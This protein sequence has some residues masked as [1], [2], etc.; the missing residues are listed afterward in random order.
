MPARPYTE[1]APIAARDETQALAGQTGAGVSLP[2]AAPLGDTGPRGDRKL[3]GEDTQ[4]RGGQLDRPRDLW[5]VT[6]WAQGGSMPLPVPHLPTPSGWANGLPDTPS[7][8]TGLATSRPEPCP[9][10]KAGAVPPLRGYVT[11]TFNRRV[12]TAHCCGPSAQRGGLG[13]SETS[14]TL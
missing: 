8:G 7:S 10:P 12:P 11:L 2:I 6:L 4:A 5:R 3:E 1:G 9:M 14:A 13:E